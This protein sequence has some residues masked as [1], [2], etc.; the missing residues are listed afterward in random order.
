MKTVKVKEKN[1]FVMGFAASAALSQ[2]LNIREIKHLY[3]QKG[4]ETLNPTRNL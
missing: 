4:D 2:V 3:C 1:A